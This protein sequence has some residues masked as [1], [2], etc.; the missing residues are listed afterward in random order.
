MLRSICLSFSYVTPVGLVSV[1]IC[2]VVQ[3]LPEHPIPVVV[4]Y[5]V[6]TVVF[7]IPCACIVYLFDSVQ[8]SVKFRYAESYTSIAGSVHSMVCVWWFAVPSL[9]TC[10]MLHCAG[11]LAVMFHPLVVASPMLVT[12]SV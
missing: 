10:V 11:I 6:C 7:L 8:L 3:L 1:A 2:V 12:L 4:V 9:Y 5:V